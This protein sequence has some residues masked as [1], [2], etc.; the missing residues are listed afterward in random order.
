VQQHYTSHYC[1]TLHNLP[2]YYTILHYALLYYTTQRTNILHYI[3]LRTTI[4]HYTTYQYT[5]LRTT[6][7]HYGPTNILHYIKLHTTILYYNAKPLHY[8]ILRTIKL[9]TSCSFYC[10]TSKNTTFIERDFH[11][12]TWDQKI[13]QCVCAALLH[14]LR[15][16][17]LFFINISGP[18]GT[19]VIRVFM[20]KCQRANC[21]RHLVT[22]QFIAHN[23]REKRATNTKKNCLLVFLN[24]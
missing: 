5:T 17:K 22:W 13:S 20:T 14:E 11:F 18:Y 4:L 12:S 8:T 16:D 10:A 7:R 9:L 21:W 24:T 6:V 1:A 23:G 19:N 3:T 15:F 2:V